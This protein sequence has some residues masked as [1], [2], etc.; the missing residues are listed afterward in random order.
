VEES[1]VGVQAA[2]LMTVEVQASDADFFAFS[3]HKMFGPT[4]NAV[5]YGKRQLLEQMEPVAFGGEMIDFV[6][7]YDSSWQELPGKFE[8]CTSNI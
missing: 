6:N 4:G 5:L 7:L 8:A 3:W 2:P 1:P